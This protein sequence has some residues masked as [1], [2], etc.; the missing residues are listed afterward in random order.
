MYP[1]GKWMKVKSRTVLVTALAVWLAS[2][3]FGTAETP[4]AAPTSP[5]AEVHGPAQY[6]DQ[7][8]LSNYRYSNA[9][10]GFSIDLPAD[11]GL[12]PIP[13]PI[14][15]DGSIP[16]LDTI[17]RLP[18]KGIIAVSAHKTDDKPGQ[19]RQL[20]RRELDNELMVGVEELHALS[21]ITIAGQTSFYF[22]TRRGMDQHAIYAVELNGYVLRILTAAR[23]PKLLQQLQA[24]VT[25]M[26]F[27]PPSAI[28]QY[29]GVGAEPYNGP[30]IPYRVLQ[31]LRNDPP[32]NQTDLGQVTGNVYENRQL[33]FAYEL[34]KGWHVRQQA[35]VMPAV[36]RSREKNLAGPAIG[37]NEK[38]MRDACERT[39]VS[40]WR[41][42]PDQGGEISYDDFGE[43]TVFATPLSCFPHVK[44]PEDLSQKDP[45]RDFLVAYGESHPITQD[46]KGVRAFTREG[47]TF[48]VMNGVV[49]YQEQDD[50]LMRRVSVALA[51]TRQRDYLLAFFFAA[52]HESE[53]R[54]LA[55]AKLKFEIDKP[56]NQA[57]TSGPKSAGAERQDEPGGAT[58]PSSAANSAATPPN[59]APSA[60]PAASGSAQPATDATS[61]GPN[62]AASP[63][64]T[65]ASAAPAAPAP[66]RPSLLKPGETMDEQQ[67]KGAAVPKKPT[68]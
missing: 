32:G 30:A 54:E 55:N 42:L 35:A 45:L 10:F 50:P 59:T 19:A 15:P 8:Y 44:F 51:L 67:M 56:L 24:A 3:A 52:P 68:K 23:D 1:V 66:F 9:Y 40:S 2:C 62:S 22:E 60:A 16:L 61:S 37:P 38:L 41:K 53:L 18:E 20:L 49:A 13:S 34:P 64:A 63:P 27:F 33:G 47:H 14:P 4:A 29:A 36:E 7:G 58:S 31:Q 65:D 26:R 46:M 25:R 6:P 57:K 21:K 43:V 48:I 28:A 17:G 12:R 5:P 39:L 11:A